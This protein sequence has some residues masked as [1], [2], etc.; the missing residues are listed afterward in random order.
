MDAATSAAE[1]GTDASGSFRIEVPGDAR[2]WT[3]QV[4]AAGHAPHRVRHVRPG[5]FLR[6]RLQPQR[7]LELLVRDGDLAPVEGATLSL[8]RGEFDDPRRA[9]QTLRT[10][11]GGRA[12]IERL[13]S[14]RHYVHV[15]H[16]DFVSAV[17][18]VPE[19]ADEL[20]FLLGRGFRIEGRVTLASGQPLPEP[21]RVQLDAESGTLTSHVVTTDADGGFRS[22]LGFFAGEQLVRAI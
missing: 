9:E 12:R 22:R 15:A 17:Q 18:R 13:P 2:F 11:R 14:G 19:D 1:S 8:L 4:E 5:D 6:V 3:L 10:D 7:T 16:P 21:A 20:E